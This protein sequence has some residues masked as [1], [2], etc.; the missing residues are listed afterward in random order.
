MSEKFDVIIVGAG[1]AGSAAAYSLA[2]MGFNVLMI[3]RGKYPGAKNVMGG[4]MYAYALNRLIP[5]FW[6]EAPIERKVTHEKLTLQGEKASF[7]LDFMDE[8]LREPPNSYT[9]LRGKFD[10]W[11]AGKA[12]EAGATLVSSIRVDD[13]IW[14][15]NR[16]TGI[17]AGTDRIQANV[18]IAADGAVSLLSEKAGL[19]KFDVLQF[20]LGIKEIIELPEKTIE[21]RFNLASGE[22]AAQLFVGHCTKGIPGGGFIYTNK[23]SLSV[24]IVVYINSLIEKKIESHEL[25]R[26]FNTNPAVAA[27]IEGGKIL[28][29]SAHVIPETSRSKL[30]TDGMLVVGDAGGLIV[31]SGIT[32]RGIDMAIASGVAAAETVKKAAQEN[33]FSK[34]SLSYYEELLKRDFVLQDIETFK[35]APEFLQNERLYT[36][37]PEFVCRL[38]HRLVLVD[39]P[40]K[41]AFDELL[42]ES[43]GNRIQMFLDM[44][45]G[46]RSL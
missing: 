33:D 41:R 46:M 15:N 25:I 6:K 44:L 3:E 2:K 31:N 28:E 40:K 35:K 26:E 37:Y 34:Q 42:E 45:R 5:E 30:F 39:G 22:G 16:I 9:I 1:P 12:V 18:V 11:F 13:L 27:L 24:G 38:F 20:A 43:K 23:T 36:L 8:E 29:Y 10:Q 14:E 19:K 7:T 17:V 4:R 32:L 21:E